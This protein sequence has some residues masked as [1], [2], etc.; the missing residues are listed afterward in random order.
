MVRTSRSGLILWCPNLFHS[1]KVGFGKICLCVYFSNENINVSFLQRDF[2]HS[3]IL[4]PW[5]RFLSW[6]RRLCRD[7]QR[8]IYLS[9][10]CFQLWD[11]P[12]AGHLIHIIYLCKWSTFCSMSS[13]VPFYLRF[14]LEA[15]ISSYFISP[16]HRNLILIF[17]L[18]IITGKLTWEKSTV[19]WLL[20]RVTLTRIKI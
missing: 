4:S 17:T 3:W 7:S 19:L 2:C 15:V 18:K 8:R 12:Y 11:L 1:F 16:G 9:V 6:C 20:T 14:I 5:C 10:P 13:N